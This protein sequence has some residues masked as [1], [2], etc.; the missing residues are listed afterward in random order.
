ML[1]IVRYEPRWASPWDDF[2]GRAK[3]GHFLFRRGYMDYHADRFTDHSLL[4]FHEEEL[5]A[6]LPASVRNGVLTSHAGL[7]FGGVVSSERIRVALMLELF[8]QLKLYLRDQ[9][10]DHV[11]YKAVPHIYHRVPAEE[12]LY[13]LFR[14]GARLVRRDISSTVRVSMRLEPAKGRKWSTRRARGNGLEIGRSHDFRTFMAIAED[15]L[16]RKYNV[17]PTHTAA[18]M[19]LLAG[20]FPDN[21]QLYTASRGGVMLGGVILYRSG[22]VDHAQYITST[23]EGRDLFVLDAV[24]DVLLGKVCAETPYFDFGISTEEGGRRLNVGLCDNKESYGARAIAYD[25]YEFE[26]GH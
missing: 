15:N 21:I 2:I 10:I 3:N 8:E 20:R 16:L 7:T 11:V 6:L 9:G 22:W 5:I 26:I 18:E 12:D 17:R 13:A 23:E 24:F 1:R 4:F 25:F 19:E 14:V